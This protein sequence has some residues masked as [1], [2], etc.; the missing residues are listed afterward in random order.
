MKSLSLDRMSAYIF[1]ARVHDAYLAY[2]RRIWFFRKDS[3]NG[4]SLYHTQLLCF[5]NVRSLYVLEMV[6]I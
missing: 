6:L 2:V 1:G 3:C 4:F 5:Q